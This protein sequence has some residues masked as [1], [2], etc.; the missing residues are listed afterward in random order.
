MVTTHTQPDQSVVGYQVDLVATVHRLE[1]KVDIALTQT[2]ARLDEQGRLLA[3]AL[4]EIG[5]LESRVQAA[6]TIRAGLLVRIETVERQLST[7]MER[8]PPQ[9]PAMM[10]AVA[11][12]LMFVMFIAALLY[13][14]PGV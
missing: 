3:G 9:W 5:A 7:V 12:T 2:Q 11:S 10:S 8:R 4:T 6:E 1:A 13:L 14:G